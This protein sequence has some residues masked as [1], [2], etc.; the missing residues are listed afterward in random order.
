PW[1]MLGSLCLLLLLLVLA[2]ARPAAAVCTAT[3]VMACGS[4]CFQCVGTTCTLTK[5]LTVIPGTPGA[6]CT[7]DFGAIDLVLVGGGFDANGNAFEIRAH[8]LTVGAGGTLR[9]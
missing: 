3:Q 7:F 2:A 6:V 4:S 1:R 8:S 9:A 5:L